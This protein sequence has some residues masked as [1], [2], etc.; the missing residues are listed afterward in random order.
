V[1][2][3]IVDALLVTLANVEGY[4]GET[5]DLDTAVKVLESAGAILRDADAEERTLL[6]RRARELAAQGGDPERISFLENIGEGLGLD[7]EG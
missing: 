7:E 2:D 1:T 4:A 5:F 3:A 6:V